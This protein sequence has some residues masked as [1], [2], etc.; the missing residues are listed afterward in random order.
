MNSKLT[1]TA[2]EL[3]EFGRLQELTAGNP[4]APAYGAR[5][6]AAFLGGKNPGGDTCKNGAG[7]DFLPEGSS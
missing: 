5:E 7:A 6:C 1:F 2:P 4:D 3:I